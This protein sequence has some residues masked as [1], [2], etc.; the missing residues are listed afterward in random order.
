MYLYAFR[1]E[2]AIF[3]PAAEYQLWTNLF[4]FSRSVPDNGFPV[5]PGNTRFVIIAIALQTYFL[6]ESWA[7]L[8]WSLRRDQ[9]FL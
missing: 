4:I 5:L 6:T 9:L 1:R 7:W 2:I 3:L 8:S